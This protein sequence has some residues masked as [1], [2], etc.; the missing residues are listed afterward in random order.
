MQQAGGKQ[1]RTS[2]SRLGGGGGAL[3]GS[4]RGCSRA[5]PTPLSWCADCKQQTNMAEAAVLASP[6][7]PPCVQVVE[8]GGTRVLIVAVDDDVYAVSNKCSHLGLPIVGGCTAAAG[9]RS[10]LRVGSVPYACMHSLDWLY[11]QFK[12]TCCCAIQLPCWAHC[13]SQV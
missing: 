4:A 1:V 3:P 12:A 10:W 7:W 11:G 6:S 13:A 8:L 5:Q 2:G 9:C